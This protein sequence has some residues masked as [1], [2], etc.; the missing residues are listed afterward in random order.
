MNEIRSKLIT[1]DNGDHFRQEGIAYPDG[2][3]EV[4]RT[5]IQPRHEMKSRDV[6]KN[7]IPAIAYFYYPEWE[8]LFELA[9]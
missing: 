7:G 9:Q 4:L 2:R 8:P 1:A 3:F 6:D 5:W